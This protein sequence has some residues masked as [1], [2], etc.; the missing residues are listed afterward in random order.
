M[1]PARPP[2][3][4][5]VALEAFRQEVYVY[6]AALLGECAGLADLLRTG[7]GEVAIT[8]PLR[9]WEWGVPAVAVRTTV[10]PA[11]AAGDA[12]PPG[13]DSGRGGGVD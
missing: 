4:Q 7:H 2:R 8:L 3:L 9:N 13:L 1:A 6:L 5:G 10:A 11:A 12:R